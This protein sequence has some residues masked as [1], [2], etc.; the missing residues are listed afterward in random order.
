MEDTKKTRA[1]ESAQQ[2]SH[3]LMETATVCTGSG[4]VC[5]RSFVTYCCF[6]FSLFMGFLG[7]QMNGSLNLVPSLGPF[8][9]CLHVFFNPDVLVIVLFYFILLLSLRA[10]TFFPNERQKGVD[11]DGRRGGEELLG[12]EGG[13]LESGVLC[14]R[15]KLSIKCK[16]IRAFFQMFSWS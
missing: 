5:H 14:E 2:S 10:L 3:E 12:V 6:Q 15:K 8:P 13:E 11:P 16:Q 4:W 1:S 7:E 9:F